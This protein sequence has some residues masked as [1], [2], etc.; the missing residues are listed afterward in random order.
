[1]RADLKKLFA[2]VVKYTDFCCPHTYFRSRAFYTLSQ[3]ACELRLSYQEI[4]AYQRQRK[5][6]EDLKCWKCKLRDYL[7]AL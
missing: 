1:M 6:I 3:V 5:A 4:K 2:L 7:N